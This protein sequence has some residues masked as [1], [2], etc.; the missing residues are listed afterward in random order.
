MASIPT[1]CARAVGV[2][3]AVTRLTVVDVFRRYAQ[4]RERLV[5]YLAEGAKQAIRTDRP[6]MRPLF[7]DNPG[8]PQTWE[9]PRQ[10]HLG[11]ALLVN[12]VTEPGV[13]RW[14]TYLPEGDWVDVWTGDRLSGSTWHDIDVSDH[15][16][17]VLCRASE[18]DGMRT[19]FDA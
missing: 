18:W 19:I 9:A 1:R 8:D 6:L 17:P 12:P 14:A 7:F 5:P 4:L 11:D 2:R 15:K 16:V 13:E 3:H 10:Y